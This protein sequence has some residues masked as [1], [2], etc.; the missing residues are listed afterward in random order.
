MAGSRCEM[1]QRWWK[2]GKQPKCQPPKVLR[3]ARRS[4]N[5][6]A[7]YLHMSIEADAYCHFVPLR[8]ASGSRSLAV[9]PVRRPGGW[10]PALFF[11]KLVGLSS[12][13]PSGAQ[14]QSWRT[15][16]SFGEVGSQAGAWEPEVCSECLRWGHF[17]CPPVSLLLEMS[18]PR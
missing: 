12:A 6:M 8:C 2:V 7:R 17:Q 9:A 14:R 13:R 4:V 15:R 18:R 16:R 11:H 1:K 5:K 10:G 3:R